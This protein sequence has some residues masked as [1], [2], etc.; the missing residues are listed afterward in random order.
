MKPHNLGVFNLMEQKP[1]NFLEYHK[2]VKAFEE[3]IAPS[4]GPCGSQVLINNSSG[5]CLVSKDGKTI[6]EACIAQ[7]PLNHWV[8]D[9]I[10]SHFK[11]S[12]DGSKS[13][14]LLLSELLRRVEAYYT[15]IG[16]AYENQFGN[17]SLKRFCQALMEHFTLLGREVIPSLLAPSIISNRVC[18][19]MSPCDTDEFC[20]FLKQLTF[21]VLQDK[22][23]KENARLLSDLTIQFAKLPH[24]ELHI[25]GHISDIIKSFR[26]VC[27]EVSGYSVKDS[28]IME[29]IL[30]QRDFAY[31]DPT[32]SKSD[33][34]VK[35]LLTAYDFE[36]DQQADS[37]CVTISSVEGISRA[38][39]WNETKWKKFVYNLQS[40]NVAAII[41][42]NIFPEPLMAF[43][44]LSGISVI[45]S[46]FLEDLCYISDETGV[47]L[48]YDFPDTSAWFIHT[49]PFLKR[50]V[51]GKS[52]FC[53]VGFQNK[54][55]QRMKHLVVCG[56]TSAVC[57]SYSSAIH[58][59]LRNVATA[60]EGGHFDSTPHSSGCLDEQ[61]DACCKRG[62]DCGTNHKQL[63]A[64][65]GGG[66]AEML[67]SINIRDLSEKYENKMTRLA[68]K[69]FADSLEIVPKTLHN[70]SYQVDPKRY[71]EGKVGIGQES[72]C[73]I[74]ARTGKW[75]PAKEVGIIEPLM[76]KLTLWQQV[77]ETFCDLFRID[78]IIGVGMANSNCKEKQ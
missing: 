25:E 59:S 39:S 34:D 32:L 37:L 43:C 16:A 53:S 69:C 64:V 17:D 18:L 74:H 12:G 4:F 51:L 22:F 70:N 60:L 19:K 2:A 26:H 6:M 68:F 61:L 8:K 7:T 76:Y 10:K 56:P 55:G 15:H 38:A 57:R 67:A 21:T 11:S 47:P 24:P 23:A 5:H 78:A 33:K 46:V 20:E 35:L 66:V 13:F 63:Y 14:I 48:N 44:R 40:L 45:H 62:H 3:V 52:V 9:R 72:V 77:L 73:G 27:Q 58:N 29:G 36:I 65:Y 31:Q 42:V 75:V 1:V 28:M 50:V 41:S 54:R 71:L 30:I 49:V